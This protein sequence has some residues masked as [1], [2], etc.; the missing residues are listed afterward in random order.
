M[1]KLFLLALCGLWS[2]LSFAQ[3]STWIINGNTVPVDAKLGT[4]NEKSIIIETN[5]L[6]RMRILYDGKIGIGTNAPESRLHVAGDITLEGLLRFPALADPNDS[7][8]KILKL[9]S[10]GSTEIYSGSRLL[11]DLYERDCVPGADYN[12]EVPVWASYRSD[13]YGKIYTGYSCPTWVGIGTNEPVSALD[14]RGHSFSRTLSVGS[15]F[16]I[17]QEMVQRAHIALFCSE[18]TR[19]G[20]VIGFRPSFQ[21]TPFRVAIDHADPSKDL[22]RVRRDGGVDHIYTGDTSG[23]ICAYRSWDENANTFTDIALLSANGHWHCQ[24][25]H[26][27]FAPFWPDFVFQNDYDLMPLNTLKNYIVQNGHL[28]G[29][30]SAKE[31]DEQ[32]VDVFTILASLTQ[33]VEEL[34]LYILQQQALIEQLQATSKH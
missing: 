14:V 26:I 3:S 24:G 28:P 29:I 21:G 6:E 5:N 23:L 2:S 7:S 22:M 16:D 17:N 30:P 12:Q 31:I 34:T 18:P 27:Q 9:N 25:L 20:L 33:K 8:L 19:D 10:D 32:G 11:Q 1:K 13:G 4:N 15:M